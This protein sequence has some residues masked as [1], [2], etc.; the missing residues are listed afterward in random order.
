MSTRRTIGAVLAIAA[1]GV[2]A[3]WLYAI[4]ASTEQLRALF[5]P[6]ESSVRPVS[7]SQAPRVVNRAPPT[8]VAKRQDRPLVVE[9]GVEPDDLSSPQ[10]TGPIG[11]TAFSELLDSGLLR[12]QDD[13]AAAEELRNALRAAEAAAE[14]E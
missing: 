8:P 7:A 14:P 6:A 13:P 1:V 10:S 3:V 5:L 9:E 11:G 2:V 4:A 12:E